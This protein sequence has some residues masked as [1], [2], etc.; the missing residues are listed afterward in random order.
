MSE[1]EQDAMVL[2]RS[3]TD[4][5]IRTKKEGDAALRREKTMGEEPSRP[6]ASLPEEDGDAE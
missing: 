6:K 5:A 1:A 3:Q 2:V 4:Q